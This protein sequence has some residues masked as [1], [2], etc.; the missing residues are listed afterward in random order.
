LELVAGIAIVAALAACAKDVTGQVTSAIQQTVSAAPAGV[1]RDVWDDV[2]RF[3]VARSYAPAWTADK[4]QPAS[5]L[6]VLRQSHE[7]GLPTEAYVS[8]DLP[9]LL[10]PEKKSI[11]ESQGFDAA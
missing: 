7:H 8:G 9:G 11:E 3:Y 5:A 1:N 4:E 2:Q 10:T 6:R